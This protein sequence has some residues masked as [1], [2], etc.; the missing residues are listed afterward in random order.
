MLEVFTLKHASFE[1]CIHTL[2]HMH[3]VLKGICVN[4]CIR[5]ERLWR[6]SRGELKDSNLFCL[7]SEPITWLTCYICMLAYRLLLLSLYEICVIIG[8][9]YCEWSKYVM[10]VNSYLIRLK[11]WWSYAGHNIWA[12]GNDI[13]S[14]CFASDFIWIKRNGTANV[15]RYVQ[16]HWKFDYTRK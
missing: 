14:T 6:G 13:L 11:Y 10:L 3:S 5:W 12:I 15:F 7:V 16:F 2:V 1:H 8:I 9:G 4:T